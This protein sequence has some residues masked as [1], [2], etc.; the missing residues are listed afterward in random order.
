[1]ILKWV[2]ILSIHPRTL[3]ESKLGNSFVILAKEGKFYKN[4]SL[5]QE[6]IF[7]DCGK[8]GLKK[9][10]KIS[11]FIKNMQDTQKSWLA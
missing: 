1:M 3:F 4:Y 9:K 6:L 11:D 2:S 8:V 10:R 7:S 5:F